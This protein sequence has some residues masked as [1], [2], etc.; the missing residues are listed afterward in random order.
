MRFALSCL[1]L[2]TVLLVVACGGPETPAEQTEQPNPAAVEPA[3]FALRRCAGDHVEGP[4]LIVQAGG[5]A[6]LFGAPEGAMAALNAAEIRSP[7]AVFLSSLGASSLE[8]LARV[9]NRSWAQGRAAPLPVTGPDG[10]AE[11]AAHLDAAYEPA[12]ALA[13]LELGPPGGFDA[14]P[15]SPIEIAPGRIARVFDTGD[16][17]VEVGAALTGELSFLVLY[18]RHTLVIEPCGAPMREATAIEIDL[19]IGCDGSGLAYD[20][21]F[22]TDLLILN[23]PDA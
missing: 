23:A 7:D 20:W 18:D 2:S 15:I 1:L 19:R 4:C 10:F 14:A 13:H 11:V 22:E 17:V 8:G 16:L 21:Q 9:R 12:D 6:L 3:D 5:K